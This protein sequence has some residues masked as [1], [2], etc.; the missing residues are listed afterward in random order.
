MTYATQQASPAI[1]SSLDFL[2]I[3][4]AGIVTGI[5]AGT[6]LGG[7]LLLFLTPIILEA[8][9]YEVQIPDSHP[10][11]PRNVV[12]FWTF[13]GAIM[14]GILYSI[15]FTFVYTLVQY[16][17]PVKNAQFKGLILALNGFLVAVL[18]PSLYL[19][20]NPPGIETSLSVMT[21]QSIFFAIIIAGILASIV[22]WMI[23][24]RVSRRYS[25]ISGLLIGA[26]AFVVIIITVFLLSPSNSNIPSVP[27]DLLWKYRVENLGAMFAFW[28]IMGVMVNSMLDHFGPH[29]RSVLH[30]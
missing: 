14:L 16:R 4:K 20:P 6:S 28:A 19:P 29:V 11:I 15:I 30:L 18:V 22:F 25:P 21:R 5:V 17:I 23:Y 7:L 9:T 8:E 13:A 27:S 12:H 3:L 1:K 2:S 24:S 26:F 10:L